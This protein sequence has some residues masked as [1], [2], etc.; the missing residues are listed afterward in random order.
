[1]ILLRFGVI[2]ALG[3]ALLCARPAAA[4]GTEGSLGADYLLDDDAGG[5]LGTL[6]F[7]TP[8]ARA[9]SIGARFGAFVES[10]PSR[11]GIPVDARLRFHARGI[12]LDGLAGP[13][14]VFEEGQRVRFHA[15]LGAGV[16]LARRV[17]LGAEVGY[18]D[19]SS[20]IGLRVGFGF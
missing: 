12:Y 18:L 16:F 8:I 2:A 6:V 13:W 15:G 3:A 17:T 9:L 10:G 1:M 19:P 14:I 11:L 20:M 4:S 7:D 5:F